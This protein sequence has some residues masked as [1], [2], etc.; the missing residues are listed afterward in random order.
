MNKQ[1]IE[2]IRI[3]CAL[4]EKGKPEILELRPDIEDT[5]KREVPSMKSG[6][7]FTVGAIGSVEQISKA[8]KRLVPG[9]ALTE[10]EI[11][12]DLPDYRTV[13]FFKK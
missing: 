9:Y 3:Q 10:V 6:Q 13:R 12:E 7:G 11:T 1:T 5:I 4:P 8:V 2:T